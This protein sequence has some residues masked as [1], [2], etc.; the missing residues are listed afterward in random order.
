MD[1]RTGVATP[2]ACQ[3]SVFLNASRCL[4]PLALLVAL[5]S[6]GAQAQTGDASPWRAQLRS[7]NAMERAQAALSAAQ[8]QDT[9]S[10][11]ALRELLAQDKQPNV[12]AAAALA[13]GSLRDA[14]S[15]GA[16]ASL[17]QGNSGVGPDIVLDALVRLGDPQGA[18]VAVPLLD[19]SEDVL[20]LQAVDALVQLQAQA[21]GAQIL[22][23]AQ[24]NRDPAKAKTYAMVLG[25][26]QVRSAQDYLLQLARHSA[27]SPTRWASYLALGRIRSEAAVGVLVDAL[28]DPFEKGR[29]NAQQALVEIGSPSAAPRLWPLLEHAE[30]SVR[31]SAAQ[32]LVAL[33]HPGTNAALLR[34]L[35]KPVAQAA[36]ALALGQRKVAEAREPVQSALAR[37][38]SAEREVLAQA[39]GWLGDKRAIAV[40]RRV[41]A[42]PAGEGRYGAAWSLGVLQAREAREELQRAA[43]GSDNRL[44][45][46]ALDALGM[47]ADPASADFLARQAESNPV[48]A[49]GALTALAQVP[50][51]GARKSLESLVRHKD[52]RLVR[53]ALQGLAQRKDAASVPT[54]LD[55]LEQASVDNRKAVQYALTS[56]TGQR[57]STPG[58][59][60][61]WYASSSA[62]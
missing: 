62:R 17:L 47:L 37:P 54:L 20:R 45:Q 35:D 28:V 49:L 3:H 15:L 13:L 8:A 11:G 53:A 43:A 31:F 52:D 42:E 4:A 19:A 1:P 59:W 56:I 27:P 38:D 32:V 34:A 22:Q 29:E 41:L 9:A 14:R 61:Q 24:A 60:R 44:A 51:E 26:L 23:R 6:G 40:L 39:L 12:R 48:Y 46:L 7:A 58:Q 10:V 55:A 21:L 57:W 50:G 25:K 2:G 18:S 36:A 30:R 33:S 5:A 16:I